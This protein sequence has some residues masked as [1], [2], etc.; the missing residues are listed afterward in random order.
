QLLI[1]D[2]SDPTAPHPGRMSSATALAFA[3]AGLH[4]F[5]IA[6]DRHWGFIGIGALQLLGLVIFSL[7]A[8]AAVGYLQGNEF[9]YTWNSDARMSLQTAAGLMVLSVALLAVEWRRSR[10]GIAYIPLWVPC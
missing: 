10:P 9:A 6:D 3:C 1:R 4:L 7:A 8:T 2:F 5:L